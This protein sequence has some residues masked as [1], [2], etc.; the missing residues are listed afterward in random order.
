M[1]A[2]DRLL[3]PHHR[4]VL[5]RF[6]AT[7]QADERVVA[8][9]LAGSYARGTADAYSDLD[10]GLITT[11]AAHADVVASRAAFIRRL[12]EPVFLEDYADVVFFILRDGTEGELALGRVGAFTHILQGPYAVLLD[13]T[14]LLEGA[15]FT[16]YVPTRRATGVLSAP[17]RLVLA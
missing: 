6:V 13:R 2:H 7:C 17:D 15:L 4:R 8:A 10:L 12:G 16:G 9:V 11:D 14:G 3:P 5:D 1:V